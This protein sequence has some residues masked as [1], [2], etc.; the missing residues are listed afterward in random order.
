MKHTKLETQKSSSKNVSGPVTVT[1]IEPFTPSVP[2]EVTNTEQESKLYELAKLVQ[3]QNSGSSKS[4]RPKPI[5]KPQLKCELCY[6]TN[7]STDDCYMIL[8]CMICKREDHRTSDHEMYIAS[9]KRSENYKAQPY[10]YAS[11][12][13]Q[14]L[15]AKAKPFLPCI[16]CGF[17]DHTLGDCRNYPECKICGSYDHFTSRHNRV[18][19]V[20]GGVLAESSQSNE[21]SIGVKCNCRDNT[22]GY[23]KEPIWY[24]ESRC[25]RSITGVKSYLHKYVEQPGPNVVFDDNSSCITEGYG[26]I[27]CEGITFTKVTFVNG[28]KYNL[29]SINQLCDAKYIVHFDDK[30]GTIFNAKKEIVLIAPRRNDVCVLDMSSLTPNGACF[31]TKASES[32][33]WLWHKRLSHLNFKNINKLAKQNKISL[34]LCPMSINHEKYTL[35]IVDEYLRYTWVYFLKKKS[36]AAEMIM[37]FVRMVKNQN[38]VKVKQIRTD[39]GTEFKNTELESFCDEKG[40]SQNFSSP[41]TPEQNGV[42]ERKNKTLIEAA[43]IMLNGSV[44]S[45]HFWT[46]AVRIAWYTQNR[47]IIIKRHYRTP[48]GIFR[49]R[50]HDISYFMYLD[51]LLIAPNE[52]KNP[53]T[54][55]VEGPPDLSNTDEAQHVQNEQ[56]NQLI[57]ETSENNTKTS[58]P[59]TEPLVP[60]FIQSHQAF[61]CMLTRSMV[62][63]IT[64]ASASEGLFADFL[65]EIEPKKVSEEPKN[66]RWVNA[67]QEEL[68]Q[69]YRNKVWTLVLLPHEKIAIGSKWVF[70]NKKDE[71]GIVTKNKARLVAQGYSQEGGI[72]YDESFAPVARMEAIRIFF[73]FATYMNFIVFQMDVKSVFLN[74]KLKKEVYMKQAPGFESSEFPDYVCKLKKALCGPKQ[75]PRAWYKT[76]STFLIPNKFIRGR[77]DNKLF[78]YKSKGDILLVQVMMG[79]LTYFLGLQ[80]KQDDKGI[81]ISQEQYTR[82]LLKKYEISDSSSVKTPMVP[83]NNLGP[84]LAGKPVNDILYRGMIRFDLKGYSDSDYAM[85][86]MDKKSTSGACQ[87]FGGKLVYLS[88]KK[89]QSMAMEF[90]S[91]V[92]AYDPFP[93][94]D[95]TEQRPLREFLIKFSVLNGQR[96]S[97]LDFNTFCSSTGLDY[98]NGK[99]VA[100]PTPKVLSGNYSYTEQ[101]NSIQQLLAYCL[102]TG[103]EVMTTLRMK[104]LGTA[105]T[106]PRPEG[107]LRDKDSG[108]N[109]PP[110]DMEPINPTVVDLSGTSAKYQEDILGA[111]E[112]VD[113]DPHAAEVQHQSSPLSRLERAQ[114][115][116]QS[117]IVTPIL[118]LTYIP[119]NIMGENET[120]TTTKVHPSYTEGKTDANKQEKPKEPKHSTDANVEFIGSSIQPSITQAQPIT[121]INPEPIVQQR[122]GKCIATYEQIEAHLDKEEKI[123]KAE[124]EARL[125]AINNPEVIK[126]VR[127]EAKKLQIYPKEAITAKAGEKFKKAQDAEHEVLKRQHAEKFKK[128]IKLKKYK[129]DNYIWTIS[130]RLKPDKI[131]D[132][133]I[134]Q[135]T[136]P[137]VI[138]VIKG[139]DGRT[140]DVHNPFAFGNF[141]ISKLDELREIIPKKKNA[142]VKD[143]MNFLSRRYKSFKKIPEEL[144]IP[145]A[146]PTLV[147]EQSSSKS[148]RRKR[149]HMELEPEI[150]IPGLECNQALLENVSFVNNMVIEEPLYGIFFTDEF[151][152]SMV[153]SP[154]NARFNMKLKKLIAEHPDLDKLKSKKLKLEALGYEMN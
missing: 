23:I 80:I 20:K 132:I 46:E 113:E 89:Q 47:S 26:S 110:A 61:T 154:E 102:I 64:A 141:G 62:V 58:V 107:P 119:T 150:K 100:H 115:H 38:D 82:N 45:K 72:N 5:K 49:E 105:K 126:L 13:K 93:S 106:M 97:T 146:L 130:S 124:E 4:L 108:G 78:I 19:H 75:A 71:H 35:V 96:P 11:P 129:Y 2:T 33:N 104:N 37:S 16:Q 44:L 144:E 103:T 25:S 17:N 151:A 53:Q 63:K 95:E 91:T 31:F 65:S 116:I 74:G 54:E 57:E 140:F 112:K 67:M 118:A 59:I 7:H 50:I 138:T 32:V 98:N 153:K 149:K 137:V 73:A 85:C 128:S 143:L 92:V 94:T 14:I 48:Y 123:R 9:L 120:N 40:I 1:N 142:V 69:F 66:P 109:M 76:L 117:S 34:D 152:A 139:T 29:I 8:Y 70:R 127:E 87:I 147:P 79:E 60:E 28:L 90:W 133:R 36:Q 111:G 55:D 86:N 43:R 51:F 18:I 41:Y 56:I 24:L 68:N 84:D 99:L 3:I 21:S 131:T 81:S 39:N 22:R 10:Q 42:A 114:N 122:E 88:A 27:N 12:S 15:K 148:S 30:Q 77:I 136:K 125:I 121:I 52:Q 101:V 135:K 6:Y 145:S 83:P 134:H